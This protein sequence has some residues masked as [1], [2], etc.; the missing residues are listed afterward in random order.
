MG[1]YWLSRLFMNGRFRGVNWKERWVIGQT[2]KEMEDLNPDLTRT[3][4]LLMS[5]ALLS[6]SMTLTLNRASSQYNSREPRGRD[7]LENG[8]GEESQGTRGGDGLEN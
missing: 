7:G 3:L 5:L 8:N 2:I 1:T 4:I 6:L